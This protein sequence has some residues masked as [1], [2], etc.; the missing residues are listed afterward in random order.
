[1]IVTIAIVSL[2]VLGWFIACWVLSQ[3][4]PEPIWDWDAIDTSDVEFPNG[5]IWGSATAAHQVDGGNDNS[6][7]SRWEKS[8]DENGK[9]RVHNGDCAGDYGRPLESI[10][11]KTSI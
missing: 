1:M 11:Q 4:H 7:W 3:R 6:N 2:L 9:P 8:V 10:S 5:F